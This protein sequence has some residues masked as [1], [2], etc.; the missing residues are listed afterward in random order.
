M[1]RARPE[2]RGTEELKET[3]TPIRSP[4]DI[5]EMCEEVFGHLAADLPMRD[6]ATYVRARLVC[7]DWDARLVRR[8]ESFSLGCVF[9]CQPDRRDLAW[10]DMGSYVRRVATAGVKDPRFIDATWLASTSYY[11]VHTTTHVILEGSFSRV[12]AVW[13]GYIKGGQL[14]AMMWMLRHVPPGSLGFALYHDSV[15][16]RRY[17]QPVLYHAYLKFVLRDEALQPHSDELHLTFWMLWTHCAIDCLNVFVA[18]FPTFFPTYVLD[19][20][21]EWPVLSSDMIEWTYRFTARHDEP[22]FSLCTSIIPPGMKMPAINRFIRAIPEHHRH[23][24]KRLAKSAPNRR[25]PKS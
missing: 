15:L 25:N 5:G 18:T 24:Y 9:I 4:F 20:S 13:R 17:N 10:T 19:D 11:I 12:P 22:L 3:P 2:E 21:N 23:L 16:F 6:P 7:R 14:D 8:Y 1:K